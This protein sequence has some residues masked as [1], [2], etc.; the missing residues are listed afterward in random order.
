MAALDH[1]RYVATNAHTVWGAC[2]ERACE[3]FRHSMACQRWHAIC[4]TCLRHGCS[5]GSE[6]AFC[7]CAERERLGVCR[8][9]VDAD[10]GRCLTWGVELTE[11]SLCPIG[12]SRGG[13]TTFQSPGGGRGWCLCV[14][15]TTSAAILRA[16]RRST[17]RGLLHVPAFGATLFSDSRTG[18]RPRLSA[19]AV[20]VTSCPP[21]LDAPQLSVAGTGKTSFTNSIAAAMHALPHMCSGLLTRLRCPLWMRCRYRRSRG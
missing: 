21:N 8:F 9:S 16:G 14:P 3:M 15:L 12:D 5:R 11:C 10:Q 2:G 20:G 1:A 18:R 7:G 17:W 19:S 13:R 4:L 6:V